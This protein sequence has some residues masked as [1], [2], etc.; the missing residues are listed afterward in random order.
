M[1]CIP[2][3]LQEVAK[4]NNSDVVPILPYDGAG[5]NLVIHLTQN[6]SPFVVGAEKGIDRTNIGP[7]TLLDGFPPPLHTIE[8]EKVSADENQGDK[9]T[10]PTEV[11]VRYTP[12]SRWPSSKQAANHQHKRKIDDRSIVTA[13]GGAAYLKDA[14]IATLPKETGGHSTR[15][16][17][18]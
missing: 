10:G 7:G 13:A 4:A 18:P 14:K 5:S 17:L 8:Q 9:R 16:H 12:R 6:R 1:D 11:I 15:S 3:K 2:Q